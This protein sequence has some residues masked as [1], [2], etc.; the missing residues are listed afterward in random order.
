[1]FRSLDDPLVTFAADKPGSRP[2]LYCGATRFE[3]LYENIRDRLGHVSGAW[4]FLRCRRCGAANLRPFP[5]PE[6]LPSFYPR[7][8][9]FSP[10]LGQG[11]LQ[12]LLSVT[13]YQLFFRPVYR[14][15]VR[16]I[17][18]HVRSG[19]GTPGRLLDIGCGQGLRLLEFRRR[20]YDVCGMDFVQ[21]SVD[22]LAAHNIPAVCTDIAGLASAYT[23]ASFDVITAFYVLEHMLD[24]GKALRQCLTLL[25]PG[26][27]FAG[28]VPLIDSV[29]AR[30]LG[31]WNINVSEAPR[32]ISIPT[33]QAMRTLALQVGFA[34]ETIGLVPDPVMSCAG[35][36]S[37]SLV[38][39]S[40]TTTV[41]GGNKLRGI[42][43]RLTG[44][45][46]VLLLVPP[47]AVENFWLRRPVLGI[48]LAQRPK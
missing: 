25:K 39:S 45:A 48:L 1:M 22:S 38:P 18:R 9:T 29:Q 4:S 5:Q 26:G 33:Q 28:A 46:A 36:A 23:P 14:A 11:F 10:R 3:P 35:S 8:Y 47:V 31:R 37:M 40:S 24:V 21:E 41:Y 16:I 20:G 2:C 42:T 30:A 34:E 12:K 43:A 15:Q 19:G 7:V 6:D 13:E 17:D 27:W 44:A 32:H